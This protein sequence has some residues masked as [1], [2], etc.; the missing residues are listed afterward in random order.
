MTKSGPSNIGYLDMAYGPG[1]DF[2]FGVYF[3]YVVL[4]DQ[5]TGDYIGA[6]DW[7]E[8][9]AADLVGITYYGS[10]FNT[11]YGA[12]MDYFL[13]LDAEGNV[14]L[15]AFL[16]SGS[17]QGYFYGPQEGYI[18]TIGKPVDYS[19]FQGFHFDG[20]YTYWTRFN[21]ADNVV[22][23]IAWDTEG[24]DNVYSMGT[25]AE[26]VWPVGGLYTDAE[27]NGTNALIDEEMATASFKN[28]ELMT[29]IPTVELAAAK[30]SLNTADAR[31]SLKPDSFSDVDEFFGTL[32]VTVTI[33]EDAT[34]GIVTVKYDPEKLVCGGGFTPLADAV[35]WEVDAENGIVT[36]AFANRDAIPAGGAVAVISFW[37]PVNK[38]VTSEMTIT[39]TELN[40]DTDCFHEEKLTV[41]LPHECYSEQFVDVKVGDWWHEAVDH[42]VENGYMVG[43]DD[44]HFGPAATM[45]R[46]QFV[47]VLY[48]MLGQPKVTNTGVFT[49]VPEGRFYTDAAYWALENGITAGTS[50]TTFTPG[51]QL[52]RTELV[53][54]MYRFAKYVGVD[55]S[56]TVDL[57]DYRDAA[58]IPSFARDAWAWA[59]SHDIVTGMTVDTLVPMALTNRAQ[60]AV[61]FQRFD[62]TFE[63]WFTDWYFGQR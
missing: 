38:D 61:I 53:A 4:I 42:S 62:N 26:G 59:V 21:E 32:D 43:L 31:K 47:T 45:N 22:E 5:T 9:Y 58:Q 39:T 28:A 2:G 29:A 55:S 6:W 51:G 24:T 30:G 52:T 33:P 19:Y 36:V 23:L 37:S 27:I 41:H 54:F 16:I 20:A 13:I 17:N 1:C 14:Y 60:A 56:V 12:Y 25:F 34:N 18:K 50:P 49:D 44:T 10:Q 15:D 63:G 48:R 46:A 7:A 3:N 8:G 11:D 40:L 35:A 57:N